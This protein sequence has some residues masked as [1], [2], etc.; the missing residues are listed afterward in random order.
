MSEQTSFAAG[1]HRNVFAWTCPIFTFFSTK[2]PCDINSTSVQINLVCT[3]TKENPN[4]SIV[5]CS[6]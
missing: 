6:I 2:I 1:F 5:L 3:Y 4:Y